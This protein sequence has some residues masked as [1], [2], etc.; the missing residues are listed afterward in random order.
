VLIYSQNDITER[1][2]SLAS[3]A[4][5][6]PGTLLQPLALLAL[7]EAGL[8][9]FSVPQ[10]QQWIT[11]SSC[12]MALAAFMALNSTSMVNPLLMLNL[13]HSSADV[14]LHDS[15]QRP[16]GSVS[17]ISNVDSYSA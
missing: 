2:S 12:H 16:I 10:L 6:A 13:S 7:K 4:T 5:A 15:H 8:T 17:V 14:V 3:S 1:I 9:P 11:T